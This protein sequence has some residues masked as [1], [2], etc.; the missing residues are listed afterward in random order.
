MHRDI[1]VCN[2]YFSR[3]M[4]IR[5]ANFGN[6]LV[7]AGERQETYYDV[8]GDQLHQ[9]PEMIR[10]TGYT[11]KVVDLWAFGVVLYHLLTGFLPFE[12]PAG[13]TK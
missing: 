2:L 4:D 9:C 5:L 3:S 7:Y 8:I 12:M 6:S 11:D 10:M 13:A 1:R